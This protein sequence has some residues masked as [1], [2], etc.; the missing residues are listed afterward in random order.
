METR[1]VAVREGAFGTLVQE[2]G[3]G[4]PALYLHGP[5]DWNGSPLL[6]HLGKQHRVVAPRLPGFEDSSGGEHLLDLNDLLYYYL[7]LLDELGLESLPVIGHSLGG[8]IAAELAAMQPR[9]FTKLVLLAPFGLWNAAH[10]L[11]DLFAFT[12]RE[13]A[14]A[15]FHEPDAPRAAAVLLPPEEAESRMAFQLA[16]ARA[17]ATSAKYLWPIPNRGLKSRLHRVRM[18][19]LLVWGEHDGVIPPRTARDF[20][21][22]LPH[23]RLAEIRGA[24]HLPQIERPDEL[25]EVIADF[26]ANS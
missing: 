12:P 26:L 3:T 5:W 2:H 4:E 24:A 11:P 6:E 17:M 16:R 22:S 8:M 1:T 21:A 13:L 18:P 25:S 19:T 9:R 23:A 7:D 15:L 14:P 10:P 20:Q